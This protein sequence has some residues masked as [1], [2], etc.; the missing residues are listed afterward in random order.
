MCT[1]VS[2]YVLHHA[3][4]L[5]SVRDSG[6]ERPRHAVLNAKTTPVGYVARDP[7]SQSATI[8]LNIS[9]RLRD[10]AQGLSSESV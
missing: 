9:G 4:Y 5:G 7:T 6:L 1:K 8:S 3:E 10:N 2:L